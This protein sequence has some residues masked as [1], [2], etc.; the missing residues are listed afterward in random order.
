[1]A[2]LEIHLKNNDIELKQW[3]GFSKVHENQ[4]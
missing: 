3:L 2:G 1:M 4:I